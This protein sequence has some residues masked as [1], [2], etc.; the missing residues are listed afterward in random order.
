MFQKRPVNPVRA[1]PIDPGAEAPYAAAGLQSG[2]E[3]I[4]SPLLQL[5]GQGNPVHAVIDGTHGASFQS[6]IRRAVDALEQQGHRVIV[7]GS[8]SFLRSGEELRQQFARNITDNRAFGYV[9]DAAI[10]AYF[11]PDAR[12]NYANMLQA[13][14]AEAPAVVITFGPGSYWLAQESCEISYFLDVSREQQQLEHKGQ[15]L[16]FGFNWN[17]D[18][19][20]KYKIALFVEWPVLEPYRASILESVHYYVD[21]NQ[22]ANPV[23]AT[24]RSLRGMISSI[25][26]APLRVKPFFAPGVWGGQYLKQLADLP[27]DWANCAWGFEPIAPENSILVEYDGQQI[28][29][30]FLIVMFY[31][32]RSILGDRL[33]GLFGDY[34]PIRF[35]Y[36]DTMDGGSLS[37]QVHP[38]QEYIRSQFNEP[39]PQQ[40]SYYIMERD[41]GATVYLGLTESCT[42][43]GFLGAVQEAQQTGVPIPFTD[44]VNAYEANKGDLFLIPTGTVHAAGTNNLVLEISSTTWWFT[45]KIYDY[46]RKGMDGKPRPINIDHAAGN[47]DFYKKTEWVEQ[48]LIPSPVLLQAQGENEEYVL[49]QRDDLLFYVHR[50]HLSD[51]WRDHTNDELVMYNLVEGEKVRI[52]SC[53]DES[54]FVEFQYAESYILPADLGE[55]RIINLGSAPCKLIKAGVSKA[56]DVSF[57]EA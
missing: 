19:V 30:P 27:E 20:E 39:L 48:N 31:E 53:A 51:E 14:Q 24:T 5:A 55:Y 35:D 40:E 12:E 56:W 38:K 33:T 45:F 41:E 32:H 26:G 3:A 23:L 7:L 50:L 18:E 15:L 36:L 10:E 22:P 54:V 16:N 46:L 47:I 1:Y 49:G 28:E 57:L 6:V 29:I 43:Q 11:L 37:L 2:F 21:M 25:A 17:R 34:F 42:E 8:S 44:Y 4:T 9:T 13:A 52:V